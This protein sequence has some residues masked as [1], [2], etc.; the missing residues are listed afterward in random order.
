M[1]NW[2]KTPHLLQ[3]Q[4]KKGR[5]RGRLNAVAAA[6]DIQKAFLQVRVDVEERDAL[7][8]AFHW[9]S[10]EKTRNK[11]KYCDS[12]VRALFS[13][14]ASPFLLRGVIRHHLILYKDSCPDAVQDGLKRGP[15]WMIN[16]R[17]NKPSRRHERLK[18]PPQISLGKPPSSSTNGTPM[19]GS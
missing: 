1:N 17:N 15:K 10:G 12:R 5:V 18:T 11:S 6:R 19:P 14:G 9:I 16:Q 2:N 13:L 4:L 7:P 8:Y 3:H